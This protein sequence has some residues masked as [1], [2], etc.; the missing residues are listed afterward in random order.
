LAIAILLVKVDLVYGIKRS[1]SIK[2]TYKVNKTE[3]KPK[4][5]RKSKK[6]HNITLE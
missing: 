1:E 2:I 3:I 5:K 6:I 4:S